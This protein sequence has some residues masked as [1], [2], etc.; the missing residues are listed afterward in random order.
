MLG[1]IAVILSSI[2]LA[3]AILVVSIFRGATPRLAFS[4]AT[5]APQTE[6]ETEKPL[7]DYHLP[8]PGKVMPD[9]PLWYAKALRDKLQLLLAFS[10]AKKAELN[11]LF[12]D[13]RIGMA[14]SLSEKGKFDLAYTTLTKSEKYLENVLSYDPDNTEFLK[15]LAG[16]SLKHREIIEEMILPTAPED[17]KPKINLSL[18]LSK[19]SYNKVT[20]RLRAKGET[21]PNNPFESE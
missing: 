3:L 20:D 17:L 12:A 13:K 1:K 5:P 14:V 9:H 21:A 7:I 11:L 19:N 18:N 16:A 6:E 10:S 4:P 2:I 15:K 8:Y